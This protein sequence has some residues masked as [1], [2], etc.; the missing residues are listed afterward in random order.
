M[1]IQDSETA[2]ESTATFWGM[3]DEKDAHE[4]YLSK[5]RYVLFVSWSFIRNN[6][7][8]SGQKLLAILQCSN[9]KKL[10]LAPFTLVQ[11]SAKFYFASQPHETFYFFS[12]SCH[13]HVSET[14]PLESTIGKSGTSKYHLLPYVHCVLHD[15]HVRLALCWGV[16]GQLGRGD[17][18]AFTQRQ[19][20]SF[21]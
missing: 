18:K 2:R 14:S 21:S 12:W 20:H 4:K 3:T 17:D 16:D 9:E 13:H 7:T 6:K 8:Q 10:A 11:R 15:C 1:R 19:P 5:S